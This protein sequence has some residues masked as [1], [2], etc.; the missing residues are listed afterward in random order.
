MMESLVKR[1]KVRLAVLTTPADVSQELTDRLVRAG[2]KAIWNFTPAHL[3]APPD[4]LVRSEHISVGLSELA[5]H[6]KQGSLL[7]GQRTA[8]SVKE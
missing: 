6:L 8:A 7:G 4:V 5:H 1:R 3:V 2:V